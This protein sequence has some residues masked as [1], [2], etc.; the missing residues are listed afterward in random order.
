[1]GQNMGNIAALPH[2]PALLWFG[3]GRTAFCLSCRFSEPLPPCILN[4]R[5]SH[6]R[7][8]ARTLG[9]SH[10]ALPADATARHTR[11]L[12]YSLPSRRAILRRLRRAWGMPNRTG[13]SA[14]MYDQT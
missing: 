6:L 13:N 12:D 10:L 11:L 7:G 2:S 5:G 3:G 1:M 8:G 14:V 4:T 9:Y